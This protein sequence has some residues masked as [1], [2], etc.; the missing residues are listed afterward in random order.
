MHNIN[1]S[2]ILHNK[3]VPLPNISSEPTA[4]NNMHTKNVPAISHN[5][6]LVSPAFLP[7]AA[8][9]VIS[10]ANMHNINVS[11]ILHNKSVLLPDISSTPTAQ[12]NVYTINVPD[13]LQNNCSPLF[14]V[15]P[16][17]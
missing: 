11:K 13:I 3:S 6:N 10:E 15:R 12:N 4:Q 14:S 9:P 5:I 16:H 1:V 7:N 2:K 17:A 8:T